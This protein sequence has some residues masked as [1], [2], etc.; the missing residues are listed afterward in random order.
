MAASGYVGGYTDPTKVAKAGDSM[1]GPLILSEDPVV[2]LEA[3]TREFVLSNSGG[4]SSGSLQIVNHLS[5]L[6]A[7]SSAAAARTN[8]GLGNI[9]T[10]SSGQFVQVTLNLS[11]L[12]SP[13]SAF[14]TIKQTASTT[15]TGVVQIGSSSAALQPAGIANAG[16]T[17]LVADL[18]HVHPDQPWKFPIT[19]YGAVGD[20]WCL[21]DGQMSV[22]SGVFVSN[23]ANFTSAIVGKTF[24]V[25]GALSSGQTS[26]VTTVASWQSATQVTLNASATASGSALQAVYGTSCTAAV[27]AATDAAVAY[28]SPFGIASE[29]VTPAAS[30]GFGYM[31]DGPLN[32]SHAGSA[33]Y[34]SQICIGLNSGR[35]AGRSLIFSG[36]ADAGNTR[37][38]DSDYPIMGSSTWF[39][40]GVFSSQSAQSSSVSNNGNPSCLGG[41][42]GKNGYGTTGADPLFNNFTVVLKD[43]VIMNTHSASGWTYSPFNFHG[44]ARAHL[45]RCAFGTNGVV[46]YYKNQP[47]LGDFATVGSLSGGASIGGLMPAAGNNASNHIRDC[48]WNGGFTYGPIWTEH[49]VGEGNNAVLYCWGGFCP[50][51][52]YGDGGVGAGALHAIHFGQLCVEGCTNHMIVFGAGQ[53]GIGPHVIGTLDTEGTFQ[54]RDTNSTNGAALAAAVGEIRVTGSPSTINLTFPTGIKITKGQNLPGVF[55]SGPAVT[56][57]TPVMNNTWRPAT[58]YLTG[59]SGITTVQKSN[60][61]GGSSAA[62][63]NLMDVTATGTF[64]MPM[65][66]RLAPGQWLQV[67]GSVAPSAKWD[68]D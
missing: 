51:G 60:L 29:V 14:N 59:G 5:E 24:V 33:I 49:T 56:I 27:Q 22:G 3:A 44:M 66:V 8:L 20:L 18:G 45:D 35:N 54:A 7:P 58:V 19:A 38:W 16:N 26:L 23:S 62:M 55:A 17:G 63:S 61:M 2:P 9:A 67:N 53:S 4:S 31:I 30:S 15:T 50:A 47:G 42:T 10:A 65:P 21:T 40:A 52:N 34:N 57:N 11:D 46:Q 39:S 1:T 37:Y 12:S 36:V 13:S 25:K 64:S 68:L 32:T 41:P 43:M 6:S 48:V 28:S